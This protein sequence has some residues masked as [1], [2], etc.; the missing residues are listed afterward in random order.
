MKLSELKTTYELA[1]NE[2]AYKFARKQDIH[3]DG[4][5]GTPGQLTSF[6]D[7]YFFSMDD[8]IYDI[9]HKC[10]KGLILKWQDEGIENSDFRMNYA[11]YAKGLRF[12]DLKKHHE[13]NS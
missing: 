2:Y 10:Q 11:S 1:C 12:T 6:I 13:N 9:N 3:F 5:I 4:W 7:Q 8:I